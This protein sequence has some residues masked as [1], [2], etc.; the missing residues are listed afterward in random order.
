[1]FYSRMNQVQIIPIVNKIKKI[2]TSDKSFLS[3]T[4][5]NVVH[6]N[7]KESKNLHTPAAFNSTDILK[8]LFPDEK[9]SAK[10]FLILRNNKE[11]VPAYI[12]RFDKSDKIHFYIKNE[13][14]DKLGYASLEYPAGGILKKPAG[15]DYIYNSM[16]LTE[17]ESQNQARKISPYK[18]I[19][20]ELLKAAVLES[21]KQGFG[22]RIHLMAYDKN[23]PVIFYYKNGLRFI[24]P[25][26]DRLLQKYMNTPAAQRDELP[27]DL[28]SGLMYLPDENIKKLLDK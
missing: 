14:A 6:I 12:T 9:I 21:Q 22:G 1:M 5:E 28:Q 11:K 16:E 10:T 18:G 3:Q 27:E 4:A 26:K 13:K 7:G 2:P 17:L 19:G 8:T 23:S 25:E 20:T 15:K 24:N